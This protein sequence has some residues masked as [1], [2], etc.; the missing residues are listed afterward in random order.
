MFAA[1][2]GQ[3]WATAAHPFNLEIN[4][5]DRFNVVQ[6]DTIRVEMPG[7]GSNGSMSF[8]VEDPT[9]AIAILEWDEVRFIEHA[10]TPRPIHFGGFVQSVRYQVWATGGRTISVTCVGYGILLDKKVQVGASFTFDPPVQAFAG[11]PIVSLVNRF[12]GRISALLPVE[13]G[14]TVNPPDDTHGVAYIGNTWNWPIL[15]DF[16]TATPASPGYLRQAIEFMLDLCAFTDEPMNGSYWVDGAGTFRLVPDGSHI[17]TSRWPSGYVIQFDGGVP[18]FAFDS[19]GTYT[20]EDVEY[21]REDTD[22]AT[23]AYVEGGAP[24]GTGFYRTPGLERAGDLETIVSDAASLTAANLQ[25]KGGGMVRATTPATARGKITVSSQVP[26]AIWPGRHMTVDYAQAGLT[27]S[28]DWRATSVGIR[29]RSGTN[30]VYE[31]GFGGSVPAP[32]MARRLGSRRLRGRP[33]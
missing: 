18:G 2:V 13:S 32:S 7:P 25:A 15:S 14:G 5:L 22:R 3:S 19:S 29:F 20:I 26:L 12:A 8:D 4:G 21:E 1:I 11:D 23:T 28:M 10:A 17:A 30:R 33:R 24:A 31:I 9:S 16:A 6:R 27:S